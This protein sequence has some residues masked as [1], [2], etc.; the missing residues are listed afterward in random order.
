MNFLYYTEYEATESMK[1]YS[2]NDSQYCYYQRVTIVTVVVTAESF[3]DWKVNTVQYDEWGAA[4]SGLC[5][6]DGMVSSHHQPVSVMPS[7]GEKVSSY[8]D[9]FLPTMSLRKKYSGFSDSSK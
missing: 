5:S 1:F 8:Q 6:E 9:T 2:S 3:P 7:S 4:T